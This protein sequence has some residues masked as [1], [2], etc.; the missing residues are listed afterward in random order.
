MI[1]SFRDKKILITGGAG[2]IGSNLV[3]KL[4]TVTNKITLV[5]NFDTG[6]RINISR[7]EKQVHLINEDVAQFKT[8]GK[9]DFIFN[10]ACPASPP[11]YQR[12]PFF[13]LNTNYLGT[14]NVIELARRTG[15]IIFHASTSEI[16]G[17]PLVHPQ[18]EG[19]FGNV[20]TFG[21]RSC[22][23]EGKRIAE[24]LLFE[25]SKRYELDVRIGRIFNT[26]GP[27]MD[28]ND[29]RVVTNFIKSAKTN[30]PVTIYG[31]GTQTRS[32]CYVTDLIDAILTITTS[33]NP[34]FLTPTNL[35]NDDEITIRE[36]AEIIIDITKSS[37]EII[38]LELPQ[39]DPLKRR[40]DLRKIHGNSTWKA[41]TELFQGLK[42]FIEE[43]EV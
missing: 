32:L 10:L 18:P 15:A 40:P 3:R 31:D 12:D 38:Y 25:A 22:Y 28:P 43:F 21:P 11:K 37:S 5:D 9:F 33:E 24:T 27:F 16:Y 2:F 19:Y 35:G 23:D 6:R 26:Y 4:L 36:L 30:G 41:K 14:L 17:D 13:T 8:D 1:E 39:N 29:G 7:I 20:N 34:I 42:T